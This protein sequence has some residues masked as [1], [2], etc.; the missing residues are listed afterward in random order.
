MVVRYLWRLG[1][2]MLKCGQNR[3][4]GLAYVAE[5]FALK[6]TYAPHYEQKSE[7]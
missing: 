4:S 2:K 1:F 7:L 3:I 5:V 6:N